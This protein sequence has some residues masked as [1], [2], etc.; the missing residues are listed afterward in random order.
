[1]KSDSEQAEQARRD[2]DARAAEAEKAQAE[3]AK[4]A[5]AD[6]KAREDAER[7]AEKARQEAEQA[8]K[9]AEERERKA[10]EEAAK[11]AAVPNVIGLERHDAERELR[12]AGFT[13]ID[14]RVKADEETGEEVVSQIDPGAGSAVDKG[15]RVTLR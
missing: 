11:I 8:R 4:R 1:F 15:T 13:K 12:D 5:E 7:E 10:A 2:A 3:A 9:E 6:Q 14:W